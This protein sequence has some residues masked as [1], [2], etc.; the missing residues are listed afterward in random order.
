MKQLIYGLAILVVIQITQAQ[1]QIGFKRHKVDSKVNETLIFE[2]DFSKPLDT[3]LWRVELENSPGSSVNTQNDKLVLN[4]GAGVT[5]WLKNK[6]TGDLLISYDRKIIVGNGVFDRLSDLNQ[7][8]M[9]SEPHADSLAQ[10]NGQLDEYNSLKL[11]Y[12]GMGGNSNT[13][14]RF[15]KY[16]GLG[17]RNLLAEYNDQEHLLTAD[18]IYHIE[19]KVHNGELSYTINGKLFFSF[20]DK[21]P[22]TEGYFGFRST[23]SHQEISNLKIYTIN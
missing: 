17:N 4:T 19:I 10:R 6:L 15:R 23:K 21:E 12:V 3:T 11:Y 7:F 22:L 13:T 16:D 5:V 8:F 14:T 20:K 2:D 9:A 1:A 18:K